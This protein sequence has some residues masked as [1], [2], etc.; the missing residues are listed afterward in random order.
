MH[1]AVHDLLAE[2]AELRQRVYELQV[3]LEIAQ[4]MLRRQRDLGESA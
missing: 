4:Q 1:T 2:R 3:D